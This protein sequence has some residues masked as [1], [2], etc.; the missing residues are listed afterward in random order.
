MKVRVRVG[1][2]VRLRLRVRPVRPTLVLLLRPSSLLLMWRQ[3]RRRKVGG[4][5]ATGRGALQPLLG[6]AVRG[7]R[8]RVIAVPRVDD[9]L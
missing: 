3:R 9:A 5:G 2:R 7:R 8:L 4:V 1:V 6:A